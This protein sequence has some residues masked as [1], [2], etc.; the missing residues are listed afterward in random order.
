MKQQLWKNIIRNEND[1]FLPKL[2]KDECNLIEERKGRWKG[3]NLCLQNNFLSED[4]I[5]NVWNTACPSNKMTKSICNYKLAGTTFDS[6]MKDNC[7]DEKLSA[8]AIAG[9]TVGSLTVVILIIILIVK[10]N[11]NPQPTNLSNTPPLAY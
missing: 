8:G 1:N 3:N 5:K 7:C 6:Y 4:K 11:K 2:M 9:I 10:L